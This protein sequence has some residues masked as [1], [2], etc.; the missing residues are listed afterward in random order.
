[1]LRHCIFSALLA[2]SSTLCAQQRDIVLPPNMETPTEPGWFRMD[3][4]SGKLVP[5]ESI[6]P[7]MEGSRYSYRV[8]LPGLESTAVM[9]YEEKPLFAIR[10]TTLSGKA[11]TL[12]E[13]R[14]R[15][16]TKFPM[17]LERLVATKNGRYATK[18]YVLLE[19][20][21]T[22]GDVA[23]FPVRGPKRE[24]R[25][26]VF[27]PQTALSP[28]HYAFTSVGLLSPAPDYPSL[29][30]VHAF[31]ARV[32]APAP[33]AQSAAPA[34]SGNLA[35]TAPPQST[36][37]VAPTSGTLDADAKATADKF[38]GAAKIASEV[39]DA[40]QIV[41]QL[42]WVEIHPPE[43][44]GETTIYEGMF[45]TDIQGI[46]GYKRLIEAKVR[47]Q[48]STELTVRYVLVAYKDRTSGMWK[49]FDIRDLKGS[50]STQ[51]VEETAKGLEDTSYGGKKQANYRRYA[52]W[53]AFDGKVGMAKQAYDRAVALNNA[54][55]DPNWAK[56]ETGRF[57]ALQAIMSQ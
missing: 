41:R 15:Q 11:P 23:I 33:V 8:Y 36:L 42:S 49:V 37:T 20:I 51:I 21:A 57:Q 17:R 16:A 1:M 3:L 31:T 53:L 12:E 22:Y 40:R 35:V 46:K 25:T 19:V 26:F 56:F 50:N 5:L 52:Y 55:P 30:P 44:I 34:P 28:G 4:A 10:L 18:Q 48:A 2:V 43:L 45:D 9:P 32:G 47:S 39:P 54:D 14:A 6:R 29:S 24:T 13:E 38:M 27:T 7:V